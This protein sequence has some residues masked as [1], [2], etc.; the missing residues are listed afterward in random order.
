MLKLKKGLQ[1]AR[2]RRAYVS[3]VHTLPRVRARAGPESV[4][5]PAYLLRLRGRD[6]TVRLLA[7]LAVQRQVTVARKQARAL[8]RLN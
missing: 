4:L 8:P 2:S 7:Y 3:A 5:G 1:G 6:R